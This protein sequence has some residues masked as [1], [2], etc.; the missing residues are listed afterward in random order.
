M[1]AAKSIRRPQVAPP[2]HIQRNTNGTW[3]RSV[4]ENTVTFG[5]Y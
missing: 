1:K 2:P 5:K 3:A 4:I